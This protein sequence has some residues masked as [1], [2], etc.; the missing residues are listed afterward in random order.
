MSQSFRVS[1]LASAITSLIE[2]SQQSSDKSLAPR[3]MATPSLLTFAMAGAMMWHAQPVQSAELQ[4]VESADAEMRHLM[5][6]KAAATAKFD[7]DAFLSAAKR[8]NQKSKLIKTTMGQLTNTFSYES[9]SPVFI[10]GAKALAKTNAAADPRCISNV[11]WYTGNSIYPACNS[12]ADCQG[13][14]PPTASNVSFSGNLQVG[15][16]LTGSYTYADANGDTQSGTTFKWYASNNSSGSG[17]T[18]ISG[19]TSQTFT[20]TAS[21]VGKFISFEVTPKNSKATGTAVSS[22]INPT[23]VTAPDSA[24]TASA[25]SFSGTLA[26]GQ[27]LTG[28]YTYSDSDGDTESGTTFKWYASD[29]SGGANKAAISGA[30]SQTFTLTSSQEGKFISFEVTPQNANATGSAVESSINSTAVNSKPVVDLQGSGGNDTTASFSEGSGG[31]NIAPSASVTDVDGDTITSITISLSN[32]QGDTD[33]GIYISGSAID[34]LKGTSGASDVN[35]SLETTI[36]SLSATTSA[37]ATFLQS[38]KYNNKASTPNTTA[39]TITVIVSDGTNSSTSRTSTISVSDVNA[40][41]STA[42]SFN[43]TTGTNLS[44]AII[45]GSGDETL[46]IASTSHITGSTAD[47]GAGTDTLSVP[48][49]S[50]LTGFTS[51]TNFETLTPDSGASVTLSE[52]QHEAFTTI[53]GAGTNQFTI[54]SAD[55]DGLLSGD[56]DIETYVLNAALTFTLGSASQNVTGG[57]SA[58]TVKTGAVTAS[59][60]LAGSSSSDTLELASGANIAGATVSAFE[61]LSLESGASVTM[62]ET[63]HDSFSTISGAG[64]EQI[65]ISTATDGFTAA[66]SIE[67]YVLGA[68]NTVTLSSASQ[69]IT[70]SS[71]NDTINAGSL[72]IT[73]TLNPAGGTDTLSLSSGADISSAT[74]VNFENLTLASGASVTMKATHPSKFAGTITAAGNETIT[75]TGDGSFTTLSNIETFSVNDD[76]S[77]SRTITLGAAGT[78]VSA[79]SSTDAITFDVGSLTYTGTLTGESSASDTL[80]MSSSA[81]ITSATLNNIANLTL[82]SG[83]NVSMTA[84]QHSAFSG[85][86]TAAG[87]E[88]INISGD[89]SFTTFSAVENYDVGDDSTNSR[90]ITVSS[91]VSVTAGSSTDAVTFALGGASYSGTLIG[92]ASVADT[93]TVSDGADVS[94][95]GFL[96]IG[97]L[98]LLSGASVAIDSANLNDF[99]SFTGSGGSETLKLMDGGT[100]DFSSETVSA[101]E[102][103]AIGT[104]SAFTIMLTDNFNSDGQAVAITNTTG[105]AITNALSINASAFSGDTLNISATDLNGSDTFVGG[106]GADTLRPGDGTDSLTGNGGNDNF[107]G[108]ASNLNGDTITD[109]AIGDTITVT[110]VTGLSTSNVRF[111]GNSTL[112]VDTNATDFSSAEISIS[113]TNSPGSTL[114]FTVADSGSDTLITLIAYNEKPTFSNLN[115]TSTF[116][117]GG[118]AVVIDSDVTV[119]DTELDALNSSNGNYNNASLTIVRSGGANSDDVFGNSGLL[120]ALTESGTFSYNSVEVGTVTTNSAGTLK[121]TF[122]S[123]ATSALVDSVLQTITYSNT[124]ENPS[125]SVT[126]NYTFNDGTSNSTGTNQASVTIT[127]VN[128]A[129]T[130]IS[131]DNSS[132]DQ[133]DTAANYNIGA[134]STTDVDDSSFTYTLTTGSSANGTCTASTGNGSF[135]INGSNLEANA[136]L[137]AGSYIVCI[138]TDDGDTT[139]QKSFTITVNDNVAPDAPSTPDLVASSD[140]GSSDTDNI[141]SNTTLTFSGTAES[142]STVKLYSNQHG[143]TVIGS[144]TA[145]GGSWQI[146]TT[147]TLTANVNHTITATATD[148]DNNVS[149]ASAGLSVTIDNTAPSTLSITT[150]IETDGQ[151]NASED[152]DVLLEGTGAE[153][154]ASVTVSITDGSNSVSRSVTADGSGSWTISGSELDVSSLSN[155]SLTVNA[156]QTDTAGNTS[157]AA[158]TTVTLD[159]VAPSV[160]ISSNKTALL[161]GETATITFTLSESSTTFTESD[162]TVAGGTL[163]GFSGSGTSY[164]AT[165]TPTASSTTAATIDVA[166]GKFTDAAG[167]NN[168]AATQVSMTV[169]TVVP[170]ISI[171]SDKTA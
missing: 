18:A 85:T 29:S 148:A 134:L 89:G 111:N 80:A 122:N 72:T 67:T 153:A 124:S 165:F 110:G 93:V 12:D 119:A 5:E 31:V 4:I 2:Q 8:F 95:G 94:G 100:F 55:G 152:N 71:G 35:G 10:G 109:L 169:D 9:P 133:S 24:P 79:T 118:S 126:L 147:T 117:E 39:R 145:T 81:N 41:S 52:T 123:N 50:D 64:T 107:I 96:N 150:P 34:T 69:N 33:E 70:G 113:L 171:V 115:G 83:A 7:L 170:T 142:G 108:S 73:G 131:L 36:S 46:T 6:D 49:G 20:L 112:E 114:D 1:P 91:T 26:V 92:E 167:N 57:S 56:A 61:T 84:S 158:S 102:T 23:A 104:N 74:I 97:T 155:G 22:A 25:V 30:T 132:V 127:P 130:D 106:S 43:T 121:L 164:T 160:S 151:I 19:A 21:Q 51:L 11:C 16:T 65:T 62:T 38:V 162:V 76:S 141:T 40:A 90:T 125:T 144:G 138:Q 166:A 75:I 98:S 105:S 101:I 120:S 161:D 13:D 129:P 60:T 146:T 37:V 27:T 47:G 68:A 143:S 48:T 14:S 159:N 53:N 28:S 3:S 157:T 63:Q 66:S 136:A 103:V 168:T 54:S 58:I 88:T 42:A 154:S 137:S 32:S 99:S 149:S 116:T 82:A 78:S 163:S 59:G 45:F 156:T 17:K 44:P 135:Q 87:S 15:Q 77:N 128:D 86:V 140:T 139:F